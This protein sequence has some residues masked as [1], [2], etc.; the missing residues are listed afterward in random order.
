MII[1]YNKKYPT[2][3]LSVRVPWHDNAWNG[4]ICSKPSDNS[5]CLTLK[6]CAQ[7]RNDK[8]EDE[9]SGKSISDLKA[10]QYPPCVSERATFM[11]PFEFS[12]TARHPYATGY[13][14]HYKH[15]KPTIVKYQKYSAPAVPFLW[16]MPDN[17]GNF[18]NNYDLNFDEAREPFS[19]FCE[20]LSF[21]KSWIQDYENQKALLTC[22]FEHVQKQESLCFFYA[23][24][25][26]FVEENN[27]VLIGIGNV[28]SVTQANPYEST[29][30]SKFNA[31]PWE[32]MVHHSIRPDFE[33]GFLLPY[34]DAI[35]YQKTHPE[36]DP[37]E[38]AVIIPN[39]FRHEFSYATEHLSHDFALYVLR[40]S[41][42]K[43]ERA[44][45]LGIGKNWDK[46]LQWIEINIS[47]IEI[48]RGDYPGLG[49]A[50][51]AF[52]LERPHF[53]AQ[54]VLNQIQSDEC[55]WTFLSQIFKYPQLLPSYLVLHPENL[56]LWRDLEFRSPER[57]HLLQLISRFNLS[58]EQAISIY[59]KTKRDKTYKNI[60][61]AE[62]L[63]NPYLIYEISIKTIEPIS[64]ATIDIGLML[65]N[66]E[67][68]L[69]NSTK[70]FHSLSKERIRALTIMELENQ[71]NY[72]HTLYA[73]DDLIKK[74]AALPVEP[75]CN[76]D[77]DHFNLAASI[78][79]DKIVPH[80]TVD[81]KKVYQLKRYDD[82]AEIIN[83]SIKKRIKARRHKINE[84]WENYLSEKIV[85]KDTDEDIKAKAEKIKA[86]E[87]MAS[88]RFSVLIGQAGSGKT[89]LLSA[90]ATIPAIQR[91]NVL[92][93][94]PTGKA[95][96]RME[97]KAKKI[98][99]TA[100]TI[101][102]LLFSSGRFNGATQTYQL[103]NSSKELGYKTVIIDEC[104]MLTEE[105]LAAL[106]QHLDGVERLILVGD[107]RQLPP[108]G[109]G[110]PFFDI[111]NFI[112]PEGIDNQFRYA[113]L[114]QS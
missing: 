9:L 102:Q 53:F 30:K 14:E 34:H 24:E 62:I 63:E 66:H 6:N 67:M 29:D 104:S 37:K 101:A 93:L 8:Q 73:E 95:K 77:A 25:I 92:F 7:N 84:N 15:L 55:P 48:L 17:A 80:F 47:K 112:R 10:E 81:K 59:K 19:I 4:T 20:A 98:G 2:K 71:T 46:I 12:K 99:V 27:R 114:T 79:D 105:M 31:M 94:A 54:F 42:H 41:F 43:M 91:G 39:E 3:H 1:N 57:F 13:N 38:I 89:T 58:L 97:E 32:H 113:E 70:K 35:E 44:R 50:L 11:A 65:N 96:V 74:I 90:L 16:M 103:N 107:Y 45:A 28:L 51:G 111:I 110:R 64:Y 68:L 33:D 85:F 36:F 69:P 100:K 83:E 108:I 72:G 109:A 86:L 61:D 49:S 23:K 21:T 88:A 82:I 75:Q 40:E 18:A 52:G 56:E 87:E 5:A 76:L 78:F 26:P 106:L 60:S 22:F